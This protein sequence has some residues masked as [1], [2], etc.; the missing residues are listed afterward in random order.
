MA[1]RQGLALGKKQA[2]RVGRSRAHV[3]RL[4]TVT[5]LILAGWSTVVTGASFGTGLT[6]TEW[7]LDGN[8]FY[9]KFYQPIPRYGMAVFFHEAGRDLEFYLNA[10]RNLMAEGQ[11]ALTIQAPDWRSS[12][13]TNELGYVRVRDRSIP[14]RVEP[15]RASSMMAALGEGM[16]PTLTR[17]AKDG[18]GTL[19]VWVSPVRFRQYYNDYLACSVGLLPVNY[20]QIERSRVNYAPGGDALDDQARR[21][22]DDIITYVQADD[23]ILSLEVVGH[24]DNRG[25][26]YDN[27]RLSERRANKVTDYLVSNGIDPN[28]IQTDYQG[29]RYP[30][31]DNDTAEGRAA[32][33][34]TTILVRRLEGEPNDPLKGLPDFEAP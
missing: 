33:R 10:S 8:E 30:I 14:I 4:V 26:R 24:S 5:L 19:R 31:A 7:R 12:A 34:R 3:R 6:D 16:A 29:D 2:A 25:T 13:L 18:S 22:L 11:A 1:G 17:Q 32:N 21:I 23:L 15:E 27:R 28:M 20:A 9:C